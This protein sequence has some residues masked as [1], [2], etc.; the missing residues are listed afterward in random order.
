LTGEVSPAQLY[1]RI[2]GPEFRDPNSAEFKPDPVLLL[3]RSV[4]SF[5]EDQRHSLVKDLGSADRARLDEYF[6]S[7]R[8]LERQIDIQVEKPAP[9]ESCTVPAKIDDAPVGTL[10]EVSLQTNKLMSGLLAHALACNQ[11][12]VVN[13]LFST[14]ASGLRLPGDATTHHTYS[15]QESFDRELGYQKQVSYFNTRSMEGFATLIQTL[16]S[17]Q[18]GDGTLL[19]HTLVMAS[20]D[21]GFA[22]THAT[23]NIPAITA[24]RANGAMKTGLHMQAVGD[25]STRVGLTVMQALGVPVP[26]FGTGANE[27]TRSFSEVLVHA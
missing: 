5:V 27:A 13:I 4:L 2:F 6:T 3:N 26:A 22:N 24:G 23:Q 11:T 1:A 8:Q 21:V 18:E 9:C 12:R 17:I 14:P 19:D 7:L 20:T 10:L 15:H 16:A 25:N